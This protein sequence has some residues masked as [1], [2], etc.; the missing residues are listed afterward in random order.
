MH[1]EPQAG[2]SVH[3]RA[4]SVRAD[5][6]VQVPR[7]PALG[8]AIEVFSQGRPL[9][10][11]GSDPDLLEPVQDQPKRVHESD[12]AHGVLPRLGDDGVPHLLGKRERHRRAR[13][14][15]RH[16]MAMDQLHERPPILLPQ[17]RVD[18]TRIAAGRNGG[19]QRKEESRFR[20]C[21]HA[22]PAGPSSSSGHRKSPEIW[23]NST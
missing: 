11:N 20:G 2:E 5:Q 8:R 7:I 10:E 21:G 23:T 22:G 9:E 17:R 4:D 13:D 1:A 3:A 19:A 12:R 6:Q 18:R 16:A 15:R 14:Q